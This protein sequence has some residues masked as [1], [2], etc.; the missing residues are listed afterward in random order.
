MPDER[1]LPAGFVTIDGCRLEYRWVGRAPDAAPAIVFLHEG[2]GS[3]TQWRDFPASLCDRA[4]CRGLIYSRRGYGRSD[5]L[6]SLPPG[7]MHHEALDVLPRVLDTFAIAA[8]VL[9]GHSDGGSIALIY[10]ASKGAAPAALILEAPHVFVEDMTVARIAEVRRSYGSSGLRTR[11]ERHHGGNIDR[12]FDSWTRTWL[13]DEFRTWN[14]EA[15]LPA[16]TC[17]TLVVQGAD[18]EYGTSRQVDAIRGGVSGPVSSLLLDACGHSP[19]V[20][21]RE[22][23]VDAAVTFL[24][25]VGLTR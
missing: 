13:S 5:P 18:D 11:L 12:L 8:P 14:I 22:K 10:A 23:V 1:L 6:A 3:I 25:Q 2:L 24:Q 7:F 9:C 4:G 17:P 15:C 19:H 21:Q 16:I 20:D